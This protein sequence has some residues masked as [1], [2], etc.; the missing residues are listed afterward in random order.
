MRPIPGLD[1]KYRVITWSADGASVFVASSTRDAKTADVYKVNVATGEME[2]WKTIGTAV[3]TNAQ[4]I[5]L[6]EVTPDGK[7]YAYGYSYLTSEAYVVTG[8]K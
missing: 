4:S 3:R 5:G 2:F 8:L 7:A 6:P 1:S